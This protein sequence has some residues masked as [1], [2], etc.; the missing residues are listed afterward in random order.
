MPAA[1]YTIWHADIRNRNLKIA[2]PSIIHHSSATVDKHSK[3]RLQLHINLAAYNTPDG[4]YYAL[5]KLQYC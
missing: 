4:N 2:L 5:I 3:H 1:P